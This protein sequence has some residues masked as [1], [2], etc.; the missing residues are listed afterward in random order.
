M[1]FVSVLIPIAIIALIVVGVRKIMTRGGG[2]S[3]DV[4]GVRRFFQ[5]LL[6]FGLL[7]IAAIGLAGLL[8]RLLDGLTLVDADRAGLA[9][10]V[11]F[12]VIGLPLFI[13][14]AVWSRRR[15]TE[16]RAELKSL[17]WAF[18]LTAGS[19]VSLVVAMFA[20]HGVLEW[21]FG[22]RDFDGD[23]LARLIV[24]GG[25]WG[26][27]WYVD[28]RVTGIT[29]T[30]FHHLAGSAVGLATAAAGLVALL[31]EALDLMVFP[32]EELAGGDN[33]LLRAVATLVVGAPVW[34]VYW[35]M[36]AAREERTPLWNVYVL[37]VGVAGGLVAAITSASALVHATLVW[38]IGDPDA[39][40][41]ARHFADAP[42]MV[43]ATVVGLLV[44]W[45]HHA[46]LEEAGIEGRG[47]ARRVYE[48]LMAA[49]GLLAAAAGLATLLVAFIEAMTGSADVL[50]GEPAT[51]TLLAALTLLVV[52]APVWWFFW[53]RI[54]RQTAAGPAEEHA[55]PTRRIYLFLLFGVG[56]VAA[57]VALIVGVFILFED[58]FG[59][60]VGVATLRSTRFALGILATTGAIAGYHWSVYR[61]DRERAPAVGGGGPRFLLL[62]GE[63][64]TDV[65]HQVARRTGG[66]VTLWP[67]V[68]GQARPWSVDEILQAVGEAQGDEMVVVSHPGGLWVVPIDRA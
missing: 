52:G 35:L 22:I 55:S 23:A 13:G 12:L 1:G 58:L 30:R 63:P 36:T 8:G 18:Y 48:Y 45:Y 31:A 2:V 7:I 59:G 26:L 15:M 39:T 65:A 68:D 47:E 19:V 51:N 67:R 46:V 66:R 44:W 38:L 21:A 27:H 64:G 32:A 37:V 3:G 41:A 14:V 60:E 10:N 4:H 5:Y 57:V 50:V 9:R 6:L 24:W 56:G 34:L 25:V 29:P 11:T 43:A 17:G 20:L 54:Q 40:S 53:R 49:I 61:A 28:R 42:A 16:D 33:G 62:V